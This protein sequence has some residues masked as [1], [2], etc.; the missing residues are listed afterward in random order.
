M[1]PER[2]RLRTHDD[3]LRLVGRTEPLFAADM[4]DHGGVLAEAIQ[5]RRFLVVGGAGS[6]GQAV[7]EEIFR[8]NPAALH[9][10]DL[11]ENNLA[12]LVRHLRSS[13]G[14]I[15]G[16]FRAL[17]LDS[18]SPEF[19]AFVESQRPY[20]YIL[21]LSALKHVRSEK[22]PYSLMR[23]IRVNVFN[24]E[25]LARLAAEQHSRKFFCVSTDKAA[26]PVNMM[27]AS[28]RIM[29]M[30]V[31][32]AAPTMAVCSARFANV[33]FSDGSLLHGFD[34]RMARFQP[35]A[36]PR[37]VL[38]YFITPKESGEL[39]LLACI[40]AENRELFFPKSADRLRPLS[41]AEIARS[42][43]RNAGYEP[44]ACETEKE[45]RERAEELI[46]QGK[47]PCFFFDSDTTGE[48]DLEEFYVE[49]EEID[50]ERFHSIGVICQPQELHEPELAEFRA[51]M[52]ALRARGQWTK[53]QLV[54][55]FRRVLPDLSHVERHKNLD[56][57]M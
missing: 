53:E 54:A 5:D 43:L 34:R 29:E 52:D 17:P 7:T 1:T 27:G 28:K 14:Y 21:N 6:I 25:K 39:C 26:N 11:S 12:E 31:M 35:I 46:T 36:A 22:D 9:V 30:L 45:A 42:Y 38:R 32:Q 19:T 41:F 10:V 56:Q 50:W 55:V 40:L 8:R 4:E 44:V 49:T 15:A 48:K 2:R 18:D 3:V 23:M 13:L 33:A 51:A 47:W 20:D 16:D 24:A 57:R 37:D